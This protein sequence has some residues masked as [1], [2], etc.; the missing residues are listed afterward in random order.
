VTEPSPL[1]LVTD[2]DLYDEFRRRN[3]SGIIVTLKH[4]DAEREAVNASFFGGR[5]VCVGL[6]EHIKNKILMESLDP[7]T[8]MDG[9]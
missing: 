9:E 3:D 8:E 4:Y 7:N 6:A 5:F 1:A 2:S